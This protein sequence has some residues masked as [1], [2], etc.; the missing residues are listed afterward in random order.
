MSDK[1]IDMDHVVSL[2]SG[3]EFIKVSRTFVTCY[4]LDVAVVLGELVSIESR[5]GKWFEA[6]REQ[7]GGEVGISEAR[8]S[9]AIK[10]LR[11]H[12][13]VDAI[14]SGMPCRTMYSVNAAEVSAYII[15]YFDDLA[16]G[17]EQ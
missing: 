14:R 6:T 8:V 16:V 1:I 7:I 10:A 9:K 12:G 13:Y 4:G 17:G 2:F 3:S 11:E 5:E 15:D